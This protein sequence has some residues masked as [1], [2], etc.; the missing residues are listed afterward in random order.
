M[1]PTFETDRLVLRPRTIKDIEDCLAMDRDPDVTR[2]I[3]GPWNDPRAHR[4]FLTSRMEAKFGDG[5]GYWSIFAKDNPAQFLGWI[6]LIPA[7]AVGPEIEIGWRLN[8]FSW[9]KGYAT[10]AA[11]PVLAHAFATLGLDRV[12]ADIAPGN[13]AS[14]R[15]A[16]KLGLSATHETDYL[17]QPFASYQI[18]RDA[19]EAE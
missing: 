9:G 3:P 5:L 8:R 12:I 11:R 6:L 16:E 15:V 4:L 7:D 18:T 10:E 14:M 13:I 1:L 2:F 17:G 19:F